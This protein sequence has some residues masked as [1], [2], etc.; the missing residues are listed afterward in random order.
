MSGGV[1]GGSRIYLGVHSVTLPADATPAERA[2]ALAYDLSCVTALGGCRDV[3]Q[4]LAHNSIRDDFD[5]RH[6]DIGN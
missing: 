5:T 4:I 6:S 1:A 3:T 2:H